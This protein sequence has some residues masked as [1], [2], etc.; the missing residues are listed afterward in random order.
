MTVTKIDEYER[1]AV[2][3]LDL[4]R[5][6]MEA[7]EVVGFALVILRRRDSDPS[8]TLHHMAKAG[9]GLVGQ[10]HSLAVQIIVQAGAQRVHPRR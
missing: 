4:L 2:D 1:W 10:E 7:G 3:R 6:Q 5:Q 8:L 9:E